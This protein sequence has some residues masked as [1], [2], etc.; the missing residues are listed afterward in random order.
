[1]IISNT[2]NLLHSDNNNKIVSII[3][4]H[5]KILLLSLLFI[6]Y[7]YLLLC[8]SESKSECQIKNIRSRDAHIYSSMLQR[9]GTTTYVF[10]F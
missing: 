10:E 4:L 7:Y 1:M 9:R 5:V 6:I 3:I 8:F 2:Y